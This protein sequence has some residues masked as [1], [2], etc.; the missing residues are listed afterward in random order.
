MSQDHFITPPSS[1]ESEMMVLSCMLN[2]GEY[3]KIGA[4]SIEESDFYHK[5]NQIIFKI[6]HT[7]YFEG[8]PVDVHLLS[9]KLKAQNKL[10]EVS[11][12]YIVEVSERAGTSAY[13]EEYI[14]ELKKIRMQRE[15]I[16]LGKQVVESA[17]KGEDP[18]KL[19][20]DLRENLDQIEKHKK[21]SDKFPMRFLNEINKNYLLTVP[22]KKAMLLEYLSDNEVN[23]TGFLP[24]GIVAMI[25]GAGGLGKTHLLAQLAISVAT[26]TPW[27]ETYTTTKYCGAD[28]KG[29]VFLG[30]G[31]NQYDDIQRVLY[32]AAKKIRNHNPDIVETDPLL[33]AGKRIMPY[34]FC[35]Q[36]AAFI[37]DGKP[38]RYFHDF[39]RR[40]IECAPKDGWTL[41]I[42]DPVSRL[43]GADAESDNAAATRFIA[44][45]EEL[46]ID[47]PGNPTILFAHHVNKGAVKGSE[48]E[49]SQADA[50]GSSAITDGVR[51][52]LNLKKYTEGNGTNK[53]TDPRKVT[54]EMTKSNFTILSLP[55]TICKDWEGFLTRQIEI[56]QAPVNKGL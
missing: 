14:D 48:N 29:N 1:K 8:R 5:E 22:P 7:E 37:E 54:L 39:K 44:L 12:G 28:K 36:N 30:L 16:Y 33:E 9:E 41:I 24:K 42:L 23:V 13:L 3:L 19:L 56:S 2:K 47:L 51:W 17:V 11:L 26:G 46:T 18:S 35:G 50:R 45:L 20:I 55:M 40:L 25:A 21:L 6:L 15:F 4:E 53:K 43:M 38:S 34:S 32:K 31:E 27:L 10:K 52:Q 49:A